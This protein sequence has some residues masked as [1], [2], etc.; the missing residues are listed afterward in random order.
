[1]EEDGTQIHN[2]D[3]IVTCCVEFY[4]ELYR[5]RWLQTNTIEPQQPHKPS[6]DDASP[7]ILPAESEALIKKLDFSK[8][9]GEENITGGVLQDGVEAIVN[10]LT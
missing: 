2:R 5:S 10:L 4:Q 1:M 9:P 8:A 7:V 6:V 3:S